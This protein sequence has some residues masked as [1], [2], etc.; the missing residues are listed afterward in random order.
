MPDHS[1]HLEAASSARSTTRW[2]YPLHQRSTEVKQLSM[3]SPQSFTGK[4]SFHAVSPTHL[5]PMG[6]QAGY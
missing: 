1:C 4:R 3:H 6:S 5:T 2:E